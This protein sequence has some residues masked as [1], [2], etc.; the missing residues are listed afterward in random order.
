MKTSIVRRSL[1]ALALILLTLA[2]GLPA[3]A[4]DATPTVIPIP[5]QEDALPVPA[6]IGHEAAPQPVAAPS[7]PR[8]PYMA[9]GSWSNFHNDTYMSDTYVTSGPLGRSPSVS[10]SFLGQSTENPTATSFFMTFDRKG[11][12][13][14]AVMKTNLDLMQ[15]WVQLMLIDPDTLATLAT[16][17]LPA[18]SFTNMFELGSGAYM[19]AD[20]QD[21][22]VAGTQERTIRVVSHTTTAPFAFTLE[23]TYDL[24]GAIP[25]GDGIQAFQ[26]DFSGRIWFTSKAGLVG[27][28]DMKRGNV[29]GTVAL[30]E[31]T[32]NGSAIDETGAVY[33]NTSRAMY[34]FD[35]DTNG[36]PS[37]TWRE[38]YDW[39]HVKVM[40]EGSGSTPTLMGNDYVAIADNADPQVHVLV[41]RRAKDVEGPRLICAEPVFQPGQSMTENSVIATDR[42]IIVENNFGYRG[43]GSVEHGSTTEPGITRIDLDADGNGCHTV[44]TN[45]ELSSPWATAKL[46]LANGLIYAYTKPKGPVTTDAW[47]LAALDFE[48]G[49]T[50]YKVLTGT[51][52]L[53]NAA[54]GVVYLSPDGAAWVGLFAGI[55]KIED[56]PAGPD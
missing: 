15:R 40:S 18:V 53:Y 4:G 9:R 43:P 29:L 5:L 33:L 28:V 3:Y 25:A 49:E 51:G 20:N 39:G 7:I 19:Y 17:D 44:W 37:I 2:T 16:Y 1:A 11:L 55:V 50:V 30:G 21:R 52:P 47:Y 26:P 48:T 14:T 38:P 12:L 13:V 36:A 56:G 35:P 42:S 8:N 46:S 45:M 41:Y 10:S 24:T 32:E 6:F 22:V 23:R 31:T 27:T 34:R 54:M